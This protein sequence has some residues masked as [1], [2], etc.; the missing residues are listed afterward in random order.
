MSSSPAS[1]A[2]AASTD[3]CATAS[4]S[5][6]LEPAI[7]QRAAEWMA[8]L[9]ADDASDEDR[10][11]CARWRA[12]HPRHELAW[13]RLQAFDD[14]LRSVP[15]GIAR[16]TLA[17]TSAAS[18]A[19]RRGRRRAMQ[20]LGFM[21]MAIQPTAMAH[22]RGS[23]E[24]IALAGERALGF[25]FHLAAIM[26]KAP[27]RAAATAGHF[28]LDAFVPQQIFRYPRHT[29]PGQIAWRGHYHQ[30]GILQAACHQP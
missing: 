30:F 3:A 13:G 18:P 2:S 4:A 19:P 23:G 26:A 27:R 21:A 11:A 6:P 28:K 12:E 20:L 22:Q 25:E 16:H 7:V 24:K 5:E 8:R 29:C 15:G 10:A 1:A 17:D 14:K 9:W